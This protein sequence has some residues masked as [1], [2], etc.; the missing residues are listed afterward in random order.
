MARILSE[1]AEDKTVHLVSEKDKTK[2]AADQ[3]SETEDSTS[4]HDTLI[5]TDLSSLVL[6][7]I[8][9]PE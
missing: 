4:H 2:P 9:Y 8:Y 5:G 3:T 1:L 7:G 6:S